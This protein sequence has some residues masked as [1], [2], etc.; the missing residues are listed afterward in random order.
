MS[1][2]NNEKT[3]TGTIVGAYGRRTEKPPESREKLILIGAVET[4]QRIDDD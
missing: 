3:K 4:F 2:I 1:G